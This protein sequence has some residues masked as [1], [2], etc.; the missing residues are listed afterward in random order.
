MAA[1]RR[2]TEGGDFAKYAAI[3]DKNC[4]KIPK[5]PLH[6]ESVYNIITLYKK[7]GKHAPADRERNAYEDIPRFVQPPCGQRPRRGRG[8]QAGHAS[9]RCV[10]VLSQHHGG[11]GLCSL[12]LRNSRGG[13]RDSLRRGRNHQPLC[14]RHQG[15]DL[16]QRHPLFRRRQRQRFYARSGEEEGRRPLLHQKIPA[17][18][19]RGH[20]KGPDIPLPQRHRLRH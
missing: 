4:T 5:C 1:L 7:A 3:F 12:F 9:D 13:G 14:Q 15:A 20:G 18:S 11:G 16:S 19:S 6:A 17:E 10:P 8:P 2:W